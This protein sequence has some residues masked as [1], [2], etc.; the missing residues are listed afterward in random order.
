MKK[1]IIIIAL[2]LSILVY[3][4]AQPAEDIYQITHNDNMIYGANI[5]GTISLSDQYG[6]QSDFDF[7]VS[8][9]INNKSVMLKPNDFLWSW[10]E[11]ISKYNQTIGY[12][13]NLNDGSETPIFQ[14]F[15]ITKY[16][17]NNN[18]VRFPWKATWQFDE[19]WDSKVSYNLTN[20]LGVPI[21]DVIYW[22]IFK[23]TKIVDIRYNN[24]D[25]AGEAETDITILQLNNNILPKIDLGELTF[26][27][28]DLIQSGFNITQLYYGEGSKYSYP[29][30]T[31]IAIGFQK[32]NSIL[33]NGESIVLDPAVTEYKYPSSTGSPL[34][35]WTNGARIKVSDNSR[36]T[37]TTLKEC[38]DTANYSI[39]LP[40]YATV[41][42]I[43][44]NVEGNGGLCLT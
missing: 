33:R 8:Y 21:S 24:I 26:I 38:L 3:S 2:L 30:K 39:S 13:V 15:K 7:S 40:A 41:V 29:N 18:Y 1:L 36:A 9:T 6:K 43:E 32:G 5:Y 42:G 11:E 35:Q 23:P 4:L 14:E 10:R 28:D 27:Y 31:I 25:Y 16:I 22:Y 19:Q 37:E 44:I 12:L 17:G 20:N 34:N